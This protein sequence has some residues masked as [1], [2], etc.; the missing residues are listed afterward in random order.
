[1]L[2]SNLDGA[3]RADPRPIRFTT[4]RRKQAW[5][6]NCLALGLAAG[7]M[8]P[9]ESTS[10]H[11][12]QTAI[13][14]FMK[15]MPASREEDQGRETFNRQ[16]ALEWEQIRDFLVLHYTLNGRVGEPFWDDCRSMTLPDTL[17]AKM[18]LFEQS[19]LIVKEE[20]ELF[21]EE[22]WAQVMIGQGL[23]PRSHSL[24]TAAIDG[25]EL[26]EF[27]ESLAK[28]YRQRA[29]TLPTHEQWIAHVMNR[30]AQSVREPVQ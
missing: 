30:S 23:E 18:R 2:L 16:I 11:L 10:L 14:R 20:G 5:S 1:V 19:G 12:I 6:H 13:A 3:A 21:A 25:S 17:V 22:G 4:G 28:S 27:L 24:L 9:L 7:F 29:E 8:E 15:F 26:G